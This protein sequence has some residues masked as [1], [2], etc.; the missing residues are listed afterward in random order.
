MIAQMKFQ[1]PKTVFFQNLFA[2]TAY[3]AFCFVFI[4]LAVKFL[5]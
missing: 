4:Y 1:Y 3:P 5:P 2:V